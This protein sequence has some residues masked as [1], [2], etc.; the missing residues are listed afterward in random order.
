VDLAAHGLTGEPLLRR[1]VAAGA[2]LVCF[3]GDKLLGGPQAGLLIGRKEA[4]K[5]CRRHPL[6][7]ALRPG[8]LIYTALEATLR[9]YRGGE[10][11]ACER[12][13]VLRQ[14]TATPASLMDRARDL[15]ARLSAC[16]RAGLLVTVTPCTSQAGSGALPV[17]EIESW[18]VRVSPGSPFA[19]SAQEIALALRTGDPAILGRVQDD[20]LLF[21]VRTLRDEDFDLIA[22]RLR[23]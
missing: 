21:D 6:Y 5:R 15:A 18:G 23:E 7:R 12:L 1:S 9:L 11:A 3:S 10:A 8:R 22:A 13:P 16:A 4:V 20:A 14:L 17:R 2:D 19:P